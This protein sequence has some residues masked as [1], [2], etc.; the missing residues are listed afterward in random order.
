[1]AEAAAIAVPVEKGGERPLLI[2][3]PRTGCTPQPDEI[4]QFFKGKVPNW[5][6]PDRITIVDSLPHGATGKVL[7][8]ELRRIYA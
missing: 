4:R 6:V 7:K 3:V 1:V 5:S 8:T 2:V